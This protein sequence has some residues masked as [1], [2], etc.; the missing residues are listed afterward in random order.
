MF[1][2]PNSDCKILLKYVKICFV[3][4]FRISEHNLYSD[5][6]VRRH[7]G[8]STSHFTH[9]CL[10]RRSGF[11]IYKV[12]KLKTCGELSILISAAQHAHLGRHRIVT[13]KMT[14]HDIKL[15]IYNTIFAS[16]INLSKMIVKFF[17]KYYDGGNNERS[18]W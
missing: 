13:K 9:C 12:I 11:P 14:V 6:C 7:D 1:F 2:F 18:K 10:W 15:Y 4:L 3:S 8:Q 17:Y 5:F 16:F